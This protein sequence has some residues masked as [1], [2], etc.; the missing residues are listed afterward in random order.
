MFD[1]LPIPRHGG[2]RLDAEG[3]VLRVAP[4]ED[5]R[6][7]GQGRQSPEAVQPRTSPLA[8]HV[9][10]GHDDPHQQHQPARDVMVHGGERGMRPPLR[11]APGLRRRDRPV[12]EGRQ[13]GVQAGEQPGG[14]GV[15]E[16]QMDLPLRGR[17]GEEGTSRVGVMPGTPC[18]RAG[19]KLLPVGI[20]AQRP[21]PAPADP[22]KE[23][24]GGPLAGDGVR[25]AHQ[26]P[27]A[28]RPDV[29]QGGG[30]GVIQPRDRGVMEAVALQRHVPRGL[31]VP[32]GPGVLH[33]QIALGGQADCSE[34]FGQMEIRRRLPRGPLVVSVPGI[35]G[36]QSHAQ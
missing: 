6:G 4:V 26:V 36:R 34:Q 22:G 14:I 17:P 2:P 11:P 5:E 13:E 8:P 7:Q 18:G 25:Q 33:I 3:P 32:V 30:T 12:I 28:V 27:L 19:R 24:F 31:H 10:D 21:L 9:G 23:R 29:E 15:P 35:A 1:G 16:P 20:A